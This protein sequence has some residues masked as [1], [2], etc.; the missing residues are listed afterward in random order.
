MK[1]RVGPET[2]QNLKLSSAASSME[3]EWELQNYFIIVKNK[4][5]NNCETQ[6]VS[7]YLLHLLWLLADKAVQDVLMEWSSKE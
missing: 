5:K 4:V 3:S 2:R 1:G 6:S 7:V